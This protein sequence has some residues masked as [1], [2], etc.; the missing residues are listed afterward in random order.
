MLHV[1][2]GTHISIDCITGIVVCND[3]MEEISVTMTWK[4]PLPLTN[5]SSITVSTVTMI[6]EGL[7]RST[8]T[9]HEL[10]S[11]NNGDLFQC[12]VNVQPFNENNSSFLILNVTGTCICTCTLVII[13]VKLG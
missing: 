12:S 1:L 8:V 4:Y 6:S 11:T 3:N 9:I 2:T 13:T 7:Y 5:I 10:A